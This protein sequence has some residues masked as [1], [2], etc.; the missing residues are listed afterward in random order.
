[1]ECS[2]QGN[3]VLHGGAG[4]D[5]Q[6]GD[7]YN[8]Y[9]YTFTRTFIGQGINGRLGDRSRSSNYRDY[10]SVGDRASAAGGDDV[11][12]ADDV[13][14]SSVA[15][16]LS[17]L[18]CLAIGR[19]RSIRPR[20]QRYVMFF[21][22]SNDRCVAHLFTHWS[23]SHSIHGGNGYNFQDG[24]DGDDKL[25]GGDADFYTGSYAD[26]VQN[27][28]N[29]DDELHGGIGRDVQNGGRG[30]DLLNG[31]AGSDFQVRLLDRPRSHPLVA[32]TDNR[33]A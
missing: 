22:R 29:G 25:Y 1:L 3:D 27:G 23:Y 20:R 8:D 4:F 10:V 2:G 17:F 26:N 18:T 19:R 33:V 31:N 13:I 14:P 12:F 21:L 16:S 7:D 28:G 11:L 6:F 9:S 32:R 15:V 24:G 5:Y 30:H